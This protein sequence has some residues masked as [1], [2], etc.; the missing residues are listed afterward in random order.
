MNVGSDSDSEVSGSREELHGGRGLCP[1]SH[2]VMSVE[3]FYCSR[4]ITREAARDLGR[5][6]LLDTIDMMRDFASYTFF[7]EQVVSDQCG[8]HQ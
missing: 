5:L 2:V 3:H 8:P 7:C 6:E 1:T 4:M